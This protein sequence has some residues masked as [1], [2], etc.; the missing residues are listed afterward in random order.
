MVVVN[1]YIISLTLK[2]IIIMAVSNKRV[3]ILTVNVYW[4]ALNSNLYIEIIKQ[5]YRYC[6]TSTRDFV[7]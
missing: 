7:L 5:A 6:F 3:T 1:T 4:A 2:V